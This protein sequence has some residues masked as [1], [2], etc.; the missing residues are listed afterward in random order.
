MFK[1]IMFLVII[2]HFS[3]NFG[4]VPN[5]AVIIDAESLF[6]EAITNIGTEKEM[7]DILIKQNIS[8]FPAYATVSS[9]K[10]KDKETRITYSKDEASVKFSESNFL[11]L[12]DHYSA[13]LYDG[14]INFNYNTNNYNVSKISK[15]GKEMIIYFYVGPIW[16]KSKLP[17]V[18]KNNIIDDLYWIIYPDIEFNQGTYLINIFDVSIGNDENLINCFSDYYEFLKSAVVI[19][20][21]A[22]VKN[23]LTDKIIL[24][25]EL[26]PLLKNKKLK[27]SQEVEKILSVFE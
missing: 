14:W 4:Q 12:D 2:L 23:K 11:D 25:E 24:P 9:I 18:I 13:S 6:N 26:S 3:K 10:N 8:I 22:I 16:D 19:K 17:I 20:N 27:G 21:K 5:G 15:D 1:K 7:K